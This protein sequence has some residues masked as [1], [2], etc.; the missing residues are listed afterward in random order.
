MVYT[1]RNVQFLLFLFYLLWNFP[2]VLHGEETDTYYIAKRDHSFLNLISVKKNQ[3]K[4]KPTPKEEQEL[5]NIE[6]NLDFLDNILDEIEK[7]L[8]QIE[9]H[10]ESNKE[11]SEQNKNPEPSNPQ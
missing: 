4:Q 5:E 1:M 7:E 8:N 2:I 10:H 11:N 3:K 9:K 6:E